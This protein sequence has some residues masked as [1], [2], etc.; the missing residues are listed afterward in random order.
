MRQQYTP[1]PG[2]RA[3]WPTGPSVRL[4]RWRSPPQGWLRLSQSPSQWSTGGRLRPQGRGAQGGFRLDVGEDA[5]GGLRLRTD[6]NTP[7]PTRHFDLPQCLPPRLA[8]ACNLASSDGLP[9]A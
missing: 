4:E 6:Q 3:E 7:Y 8:T 1:F 5:Y 2:Q 9:V